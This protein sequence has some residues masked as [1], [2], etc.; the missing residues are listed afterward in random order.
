MVIPQQI[1]LVSSVSKRLIDVITALQGGNKAAI[2]SCFTVKL[3]LI[4]RNCYIIS[5]CT[6]SA[7][8]RTTNI[9]INYKNMPII[10]ILPNLKTRIKH[11]YGDSLVLLETRPVSEASKSHFQCIPELYIYMPVSLLYLDDSRM[12]IRCSLDY[13][14]TEKPQQ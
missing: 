1:Q 14:H 3:F 12:Q 4:N 8:Q 2:N 7:K 10:S 11:T 13:I 9:E 6:F 5:I